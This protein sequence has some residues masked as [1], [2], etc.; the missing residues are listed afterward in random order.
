MNVS[1]SGP[2][3]EDD[4]A[5]DARAAVCY[6]LAMRKASRKLIRFYDGHLEPHGLTIGQFGIMALIAQTKVPTVQDVADALDLDQ[7]AASRA[8]APLE[9]DG[10]VTSQSDPVDRRR[11]I[12]SLSSDGKERLH[13]ATRAWHAAQGEIGARAGS[14]DLRELIAV[15]DEI[16]TAR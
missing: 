8:L 4:H 10:L 1:P 6:C 11:R 13:A 7:S 14:V 12:V 2:D 3:V 5:G 15:I 16:G 9:R